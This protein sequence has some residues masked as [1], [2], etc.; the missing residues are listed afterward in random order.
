M[1]ER[2]SLEESFLPLS[3]VCSKESVV[4]RNYTP[5][6]AASECPRHVLIKARVWESPSRGVQ[7]DADRNKP[8]PKTKSK[9]EPP[10]V[11]NNSR[12]LERQFP[13]P[14]TVHAHEQ[15]IFRGLYFSIIYANVAKFLRTERISP[16]LPPPT[17]IGNTT[18]GFARAWV[19]CG[20]RLWMKFQPKILPPPLYNLLE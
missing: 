2:E 4:K 9:G 10:P 7:R 17:S 1:K 5:P 14:S 15:W 19:A 20:G 16:S 8:K 18:F 11:G 12:V 3:S 6:L 13:W